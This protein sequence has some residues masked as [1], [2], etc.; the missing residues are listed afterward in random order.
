M[1]IK[2]YFRPPILCWA[3]GSIL[4]TSK[5]SGSWAM[6]MPSF[7]KLLLLLLHLGLLVARLISLTQQHIPEYQRTYQNH[8]LACHVGNKEGKERKSGSWSFK[9]P[10]PSLCGRSRSLAN[11][12]L[13]LILLGNWQRILVFTSCKVSIGRSRM[14]QIRMRSRWG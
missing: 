10:V 3:L 11:L 1:C 4:I 13:G 5:I 2:L 12:N 14:S 7:L 8:S 9:V 6:S